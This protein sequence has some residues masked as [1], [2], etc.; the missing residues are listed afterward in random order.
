MES[1]GIWPVVLREGDLTL[2]P[3][4]LRDRRSWDQVRMLNREWLSP[5]EATQPT[6]GAEEFQRKLPTFVEMVMQHRREGRTLRTISLAIWVRDDGKDRFVG[7][8]TL[9]GLVFGALRGAHVGYWIDDFRISTTRSPSNR[10]QSEARKYRF[11]TGRREM[12]IHL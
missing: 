2:R 5:W 8:I 12:R 3:L 4:R 9:G 6:C 1:Q 7:Q 11:K 10:N